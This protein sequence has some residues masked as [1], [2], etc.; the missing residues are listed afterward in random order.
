MNEA[1]FTELVNLYFDREISSAEIELLRESLAACPDRKCEFEARYR[2]HQA[3]RMAVAPEALEVAQFRELVAKKTTRA[4]RLTVWVLGSGIAACVTF[5]VVLLRPVIQ[6]SSSV[7]TAEELTEVARSDM[8]RFA[9]TRGATEARRGSLASE[10]RLMG[11]TPDMAPA[12]RQL[13][14]VDVEA[15]RQR[16]ARRQREIDRMNQ[17]KAYSM[18]PEPQLFESLQRPDRESQT[19]RWPAGFQSSL[20]SF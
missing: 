13:S 9:A 2:L 20:A 7:A 11:L 15:L 10:W 19:Q 1:K 12:E 14:G 3:M 16:E 18:M 4:S 6:E 8:A 17:Y 5:G